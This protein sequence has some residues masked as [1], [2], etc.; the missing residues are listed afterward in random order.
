MQ[1]LLTRVWDMLIGREHGPLAFRLVIHPMVGAVLAIRAWVKDARAG[2][3]PNRWAILTDPIRR[4]ELLR[5]SG[6]D[7]AR[8]SSA[9]R[10]PDRI[11][12]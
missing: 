10:F 1:E 5:E 12:F 3:A 9:D 4:D 2:R 7:V 6:H 8:L 11:G